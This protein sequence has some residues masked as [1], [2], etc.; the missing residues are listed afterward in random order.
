MALALWTLSLSSLFAQNN[1]DVNTATYLSSNEK[2]QVN[3]VDIGPDSSIVVVG[4]LH[5]YVMP[6]S[7]EHTLLGGGTGTIVRLNSRG[8]SVKSITRVPGIVKDIQI[9]NT[10]E[11]AVCGSFGVGVLNNDASDF[12]WYDTTILKGDRNGPTTLFYG[13]YAQA[14]V[15]P[16]YRR[17]TSR[18]SIGTDGTVATLQQ[19][20]WYGSPHAYIYNAGG[21]RIFDTIFQV[22]EAREFHDRTFDTFYINVYP[23]DICVD[24]KNQSVIIGGWNPRKDHSKNMQNH[25]IHMPFLRAYDYSGNLKWSNYDWRA[26]DIYDSIDYYADS[27][28]NDI[29][30]GRDGYLYTTGYIHGGDHMFYIGPK[31]IEL[32]TSLQVSFDDYSTPHMMGAGIDHAYVCK[33]EPATGDMLKG[34]AVLVRKQPGGGGRPN[35]SVA[36]G[37]MA[38]EEG[39]VIVAGYCQPYIKNRDLQTI[40]DIPVGERDTSEAFIMIIN[41]D[42][43]SREIYTVVTKDRLEGAFWGVGYRYGIA[44]AAGEVFSGEAITTDNA[45]QQNRESNFDGYLITWGEFDP[46]LVNVEQQKKAKNKLVIYPSVTNTSTSVKSADAISKLIMRNSSGI[47]VLHVHKVGHHISLDLSPLPPGIYLIET[48]TEKER[49]VNKILKK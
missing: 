5:D 26:K 7:F 3:A 15:K 36:R 16:R 25:P 47:E 21:Q 40:N 22:F 35:Q 12:I 17:P 28:I 46:T 38:D 34:Q 24:G 1:F 31:E 44:A 4:M 39:K 18:V 23:H 8:T 29:V 45:I 43:R 2:D 49:F 37:I 6:G 48:Y 41:P 27:R 42:W 14:S 19:N 11:I 33:Y 30:I 10:G 20:V 13:W 9:A 32:N